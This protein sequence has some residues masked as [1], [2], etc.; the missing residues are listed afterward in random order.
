MIGLLDLRFSYAFQDIFD[1]DI[2]QFSDCLVDQ[3]LCHYVF[4]VLLAGLDTPF[5][6]ASVASKG[7]LKLS[8]DECS[9]GMRYKAR[10]SV[11]VTGIKGAQ[12]DDEFAAQEGNTKAEN[13]GN[14]IK[15]M[16]DKAGELSSE[17][18]GL[19]RDR[20]RDFNAQNL[21]LLREGVT[22]AQEKTQ[23][24][25]NSRAIV[26][27]LLRQIFTVFDNSDLLNSTASA[28]LDP[29]PCL[30][31][32][33]LVRFPPKH[34]VRTSRTLASIL[35]PRES[36]STADLISSLSLSGQPICSTSCNPNHI[37]SITRRPRSP[38]PGADTSAVRS[39]LSHPS[40]TAPSQSDEH[41][42]PLNQTEKKNIAPDMMSRKDL[43]DNYLNIPSS[44]QVEPYSVSDPLE[45]FPAHSERVPLN[46]F[47]DALLQCLQGDGYDTFHVADEI[48]RSKCISNDQ[49][50]TFHS[51]ALILAIICNK[52]I[53]HHLLRRAGV[54]PQ[55][56]SKRLLLLEELTGTVRSIS[57]ADELQE[58]EEEENVLLLSFVASNAESFEVLGNS[59]SIFGAD[60]ETVTTLPSNGTTA[61]DTTSNTTIAITGAD[62]VAFA[63]HLAMEKTVRDNRSTGGG[64]ESYR[65][66]AGSDSVTFCAS[67]TYGGVM[68]PSDGNHNRLAEIHSFSFW[69]GIRAIPQ[70]PMSTNTATTRPP[71]IFSQRSGSSS[72]NQKLL[73]SLT[74]SGQAKLKKSTQEQVQRKRRNRLDD[75]DDRLIEDEYIDH[76]TNTSSPAAA[77]IPAAWS[78]SSGSISTRDTRASFTSNACS[79]SSTDSINTAAPGT[80]SSIR[81]NCAVGGNSADETCLTTT[82]ADQS[83][84]PPLKTRREAETNNTHMTSSATAVPTV[85]QTLATKPK[86][87]DTITNSTRSLLE[88][89][90]I[91]SLPLASAQSGTTKA[92]ALEYPIVLID[93]LLQVLDRMD[94]LDLPTLQLLCKLVRSISVHRDAEDKPCLPFCRFVPFVFLNSPNYCSGHQKFIGL[95][96][97]ETASGL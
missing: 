69:D 16:R 40:P 87:N 18:E 14:R 77:T 23:P 67:P 70:C 44:D 93:L 39:N 6:G 11:E 57:E 47:R 48:S 22:E 53:D 81:K 52:G 21:E 80:T 7:D 15:K 5:E 19:E 32:H 51:M 35:H 34:G 37:S 29:H 30:L 90:E 10:D 94:T 84:S 89:P 25:G 71:N 28:L 88:V 20:D 26:M 63:A 8:I 41:G 73:H 62:T 2:Q 72:E 50:L 1:L 55:A 61:S 33:A 4:P 86:I 45:E 60:S 97:R 17:T 31:I 65:T 76:A 24:F 36:I 92:Y 59:K 78:S 9:G 83:K 66:H 49:R 58:E 3:L 46:P 38:K 54:C 68:P 12:K 95:F 56:Y 27:H 43:L 42:D 85:Q 91:S 79:S 82:T 74:L 64:A 13:D 75:F 96:N